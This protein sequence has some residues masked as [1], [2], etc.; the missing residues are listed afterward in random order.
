MRDLVRAMTHISLV[1][2]AVNAAA[3]SRASP[4]ESKRAARPTGA[5]CA[6]LQL[7]RGRKLEAATN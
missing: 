1:G 7:A 6:R 2:V 5:R 4:Q 3:A